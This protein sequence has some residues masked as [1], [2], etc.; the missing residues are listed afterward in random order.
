MRKE[1]EQEGLMPED[2]KQAWD[3]VRLCAE[4]IRRRRARIEVQILSDG[5]ER[6]YTKM[7]L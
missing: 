7:I 3:E 2:L 5:T 4:M 1:K 6:R